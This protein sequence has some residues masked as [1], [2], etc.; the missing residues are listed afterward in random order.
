MVIAYGIPTLACVKELHFR[1][2]C[3]EFVTSHIYAKRDAWCV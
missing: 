3:D 1:Q 2:W